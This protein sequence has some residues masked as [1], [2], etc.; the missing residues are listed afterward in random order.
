MARGSQTDVA[1]LAALSVEPMTG[2]VLRAA[3]QHTL[4]HFWSESFGQIY[5][6]LSRL[7]AEGLVER[8]DA[9]AGRAGSAAFQLTSAGRETLVELLSAPPA[10]S[11]PRNGL[12]L[13]LFFGN[14]LGAAAC[15]ALVSEARAKAEAQLVALA[16]ARAE[17][18]ADTEHPDK[19]PYWLMT[20][21]AGE[22]SARAAI[23]WA[24]ETIDAL[25]ALEERE[26]RAQTAAQA[27]HPENLARPVRTGPPTPA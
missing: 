24:D 10:A 4:G 17:A 11:T 1:V 16:Q 27:E 20:I 13:R 26:L 2:Y 14:V 6:S 19:V 15:R 7:T 18:A 12:L 21:S 23:A 8:T 22:H 5:P 9:P 3:I 25:S